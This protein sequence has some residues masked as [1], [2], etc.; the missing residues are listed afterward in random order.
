MRYYNKKTY[1]MRN[2]YKSLIIISLFFAPLGCMKTER[3]DPAQANGTLSQLE[4]I[5]VWGEA[6]QI[7]QGLRVVFFNLDQGTSF[8]ENL[9]GTGGI[10]DMSPGRYSLL[11]FNNDSERIL[12]TNLYEYE[13][14]SGYTNQTPITY[15]EDSILGG[16]AYSQ[17]D[18]LWTNALDTCEVMEGRQVLNVYPSQMVKSYQINVIVDGLKY[19]SAAKG[20]V[21]G[22]ITMIKLKN[23]S[24]VDVPGNI[25]TSV[26]KFEDGLSFNFKSFGVVVDSLGSAYSGGL[27]SHKLICSIVTPNNSYTFNFEIT[28]ELD[29]IRNGGSFTIRERMNVPEEE[30][31]SDGFN[32]SVDEWGEVI[33]SIP[34]KPGKDSISNNL[35]NTLD[36]IM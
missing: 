4:I 28:H 18:I 27:L 5:P 30:L 16:V 10:V 35:E 13:V 23:G 31:P 26:Q 15:I 20:I 11:V 14:Y 34:L 6:D 29:S 19:V 1:K 12:F 24:E 33:I 2:I 17:P 3:C 32:T 36:S 22:L 8:T 21:T 9:P 7:P 25:I